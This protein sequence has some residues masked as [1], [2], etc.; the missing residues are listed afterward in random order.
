MRLAGDDMVQR[1]TA[2]LEFSIGRMSA[3]AG[4][5][6]GKPS[7]AEAEAEPVNVEEVRRSIRLYATDSTHRDIMIALLVSCRSLCEEN[8]ESRLGAGCSTLWL[9][10]FSTEHSQAGASP[11]TG[12]RSSAPIPAPP[13]IGPPHRLRRSAQGFHRLNRLR[14][15][16]NVWHPL[17]RPPA[18][19][20]LNSR[21]V[22][23]LPARAFLSKA[24]ACCGRCSV[25]VDADGSGAS[26]RGR[27]WRT[28]RWCRRTRRPY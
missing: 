23:R 14:H 7:D 8:L 11:E 25:R 24:G 20:N 4:Q 10:R 1:L 16:R 9:C 15:A 3:L 21:T 2:A 22:L 28:R 27:L 13:C 5:Q 17:P 18:L 6:P 12:H 26:G 19:S